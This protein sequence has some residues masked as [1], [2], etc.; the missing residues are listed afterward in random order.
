MPL[1][2][3]GEIAASDS[4]KASFRDR[5]PGRL[6]RRFHVSATQLTGIDAREPSL[7]IAGASGAP[8]VAC[9]DKRPAGRR[10]GVRSAV[11]GLNALRQSTVMVAMAGPKAPPSW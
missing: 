1:A 3:R 11:S 10:D 4:L 5:A 9:G 8:K 7:R 2:V 6:P